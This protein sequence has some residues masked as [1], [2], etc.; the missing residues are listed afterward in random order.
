MKRLIAAALAAT[1]LLASASAASAANFSFTG[2]LNGDD[3]VVVFDF[4]VGAM[5]NVTFRT[6]S[7]AGGVNAAGQTIARGGFDSILS[8]YDSTGAR[9][10]YNDDGGCA[11]VGQD[12]VSGSCWDTYLN[13]TL[14]AGSY[15][16]AVSQFDNVGP[17]NINDPWPGSGHV[18]YNGRDSHWAFD[19]LNV[20]AAT[21]S[22][23][24]PEPASWAMMILGVGLAGASLR[25]RRTTQA[26]AV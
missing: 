9:I 12:S 23:A 18:N 5:S 21:Q 24:V 25:R 17:V 19:V 7:Y 3:D 1:S 13:T 20:S 2:N 14:A 16:V 6:Y 22:G 10:G 15:K 26:A 8:V 11:L 4:T